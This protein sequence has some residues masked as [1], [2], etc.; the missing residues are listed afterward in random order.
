MIEVSDLKHFDTMG[1]STQLRYLALLG[2]TGSGKSLIG[3]ALRQLPQ[4]V[5]TTESLFPPC[6]AHVVNQQLLPE[7]R[8]ALAAGFA[9]NLQN[10]VNSGAAN[11]FAN[12]WTEF[13]R[14]RLQLAQ[15][16]ARARHRRKA[17]LCVFE[18]NFFSFAPHFV[19]ES[20]PNCRIICMVRDGRDCADRLKHRYDT[21][22]DKNLTNLSNAA[23]LIGTKYGER[24]VPWWVDADAHEEFL[25]CTALLRCMWFWKAIAVRLRKFLDSLDA[26]NRQRVIVIKYEELV[27]NPSAT[28][29]RVWRFI[30]K[31]GAL[32]RFTRTRALHSQEIGR[33][34]TW[35]EDDLRAATDL[36][37]DELTYFG[38]EP[39]VGCA[40]W[41]SGSTVRETVKLASSLR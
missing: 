25:N 26:E 5:I 20:L 38:Y 12:A 35:N 6:I 27:T 13:L 40:F 33:A 14:G 3:N 17:D 24:Y 11:S 16:I 23:I 41:K 8:F 21:F 39:D 1:N 31:D 7:V 30:S 10:F 18:S 9:G 15:L 29:A 36:A 32:F 19:F 4:A 22:S 2:C 37:A 34:S 28:L